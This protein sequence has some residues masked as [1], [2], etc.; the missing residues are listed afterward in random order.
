MV[1]LILLSWLIAM[2]SVIA[3]VPHSLANQ[4]VSGNTK[5]NRFYPEAVST[6]LEDLER[7]VQVIAIFT[8]GLWVYFKFLK[9]RTF[10]PRLELSVSGSISRY[11]NS[12][13]M[14]VA[15][16]L[17]NVGFSQVDLE[18][19]GTAC[20]VEHSDVHDLDKPQIIY[21]W[22]ELGLTRIFENHKWIE[23]GEVI[24]DYCAVIIPTNYAGIFR[25][26]ARVVS[27][28]VEEKGIEWNTTSIVMRDT[29][30]GQ[31]QSNR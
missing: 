25:V 18:K 5:P 26:D 29:L 21:N 27:Q 16:V 3:V 14:I 24:L 4:V 7:V 31:N 30:L 6:T 20:I 11:D 12:D 8:G 15:I 1:Q 28:S 10:R 9:G 17:K 2:G 13:Y 19:R 22:V 23:S